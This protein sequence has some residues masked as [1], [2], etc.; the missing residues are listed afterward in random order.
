MANTHCSRQ[1]PWHCDYS[2]EFLPHGLDLARLDS[3]TTVP[4]D[5]FLDITKHGRISD[6]LFRVRCDGERCVMKIVGF[7]HEIRYLQQEV[8]VYAALASSGFRPAPRF[9]GLV[10]EETKNR[11][12]GF[13]M[14]EIRGRPAGIE[15]LQDCMETARQLHAYGFIHGDLNRYNFLITDHGTRLIDF[16]SSVATGDVGPAVAEEEL[17]SLESNLKDETGIGKRHGA[18]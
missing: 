11:T 16:E 4:F 6:R 8:A 17:K 13:L 10:Y 2:N 9:K 5:N 7:K 12:I 18:T 3:P 1:P 14:E 15:D